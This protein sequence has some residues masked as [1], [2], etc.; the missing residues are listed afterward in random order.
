MWFYLLFVVF[1]IIIGLILRHLTSNKRLDLRD[2]HVLITGGTKGIGYSLAVL[3]IESGANVSVIARNVDDLENT[4]MSLLKKCNTDAKQKVMTFSLDVTSDIYDME[5]MITEAES[6]SGPINMLMCCAGTAVSMR[7]DE[8]PVEEFRRMVDINYLGTVSVI[9]A[10]LPSM[11]T[12]GG[13]NIV[14]F[15][16]IAGIFGLYGFGAYSPTKFAIVGLAQVLAMELKSHN[17]SV[18]VSYPPDTDTPGFANEQINKPIETKLISDSGGLYSPDIVAKHTLTDALSGKFHS[19][20]GFESWMVRTLC[21][22]M[23]PFTS[24]IEVI[25]QVLTMGLFRIVG[26]IFLAKCDSIIKKCTQEKQI[27][28]K[29][30]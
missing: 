15:S 19:T 25:L 2:K 12:A 5:R 30:D 21:C 27:N 9:K 13:G 4:K 11:K 10:C 7:F 26:I 8:T 14:L 20:V 16:S 24:T 3:A 28:K 6:V 23:S 22:G 1:I 29:C 18:T 17:I